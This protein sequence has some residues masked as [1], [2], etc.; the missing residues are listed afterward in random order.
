MAQDFVPSVVIRT[1]LKQ[2]M[3]KQNVGVGEKGSKRDAK[4]DHLTVFIHC[5][6]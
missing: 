3:S 4:S 5:G 1:N 2:E 6:M